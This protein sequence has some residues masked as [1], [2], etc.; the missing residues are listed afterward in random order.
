MILTVTDDPS[1]KK[2]GPRPRGP[3]RKSHDG[4]LPGEVDYT[5]PAHERPKAVEAFDKMVEG[6]KKWLKRRT[7]NV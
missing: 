6:R 4:A 7:S 5:T 2:H 3:E 1:K